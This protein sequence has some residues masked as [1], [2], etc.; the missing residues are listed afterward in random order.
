MPAFKLC[1]QQ[2]NNDAL[3]SIVNARSRKLASTCFS[4]V[5]REA[6]DAQF[7]MLF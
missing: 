2:K 1:S 6:M 7:S 4:S 3:G 5:K